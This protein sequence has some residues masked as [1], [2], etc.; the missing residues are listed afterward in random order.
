MGFSETV[1]FCV[2]SEIDC[3]S[4]ELKEYIISVDI[5]KDDLDS[6]PVLIEYLGSMLNRYD[7][8]LHDGAREICMKVLE[9][10]VFNIK[11]CSNVE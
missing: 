11:S 10:L 2:E 1:L 5:E 4:D 8:Y 3:I 6:D 7:V 9:I